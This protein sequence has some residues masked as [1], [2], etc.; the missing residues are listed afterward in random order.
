MH[1][2]DA[3][4]DGVRR[5]HD[6]LAAHPEAPVHASPGGHGLFIGPT[7]GTRE[8]S[9]TYLVGSAAPEPTI[10]RF[11]GIGPEDFGPVELI[12]GRTGQLIARVNRH[13]R[14]HLEDR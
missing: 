14:K 12:D 10:E 6:A 4:R 3:Y 8:F 2:S 5:M 11:D 7:P 13:M 1:A 9:E